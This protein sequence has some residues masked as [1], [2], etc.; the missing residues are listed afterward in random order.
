MPDWTYSGDP[1]S[2]DLDAVRF[3]IGDTDAED[4]LLKD[5]ELLYTLNEEGNILNA[6]ARSCE[7]L[8][9]KFAREADKRLGPLSISLSQRS[10]AYRELA[11]DLRT[12]SR[13]SK[14][15]PY[16]GNISK[17]DQETDALDNDIKQPA[18]RRNL[19][20]GVNTDLTKFG[21]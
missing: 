8:A 1:A 14:G 20:T 9:K 18:F 10:K 5:K 16:A 11:K 13:L 4:P 2:S 12:R 15:T 21:E 7:A 19:M 6:A 3:E 17:T